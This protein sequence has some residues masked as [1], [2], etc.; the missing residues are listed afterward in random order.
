MLLITAGRRPLLP[1]RQ[2]LLHFSA[3]HPSWRPRLS[4]GLRTQNGSWSRRLLAPGRR[5]TARF[6]RQAEAS[7]R[8]LDCMGH[9]AWAL[10][11][12]CLLRAR[13]SR[14][15]DGSRFPDRSQLLDRPWQQHS[16]AA[17]A[18]W[19]R[20]ASKLVQ[21]TQGERGMSGAVTRNNGL[22]HTW[23]WLRGTTPG[24]L[25]TAIR[26][27]GWGVVPNQ[28]L[29]P[30]LANVTVGA[31][32]YT[33]YLQILGQLHEESARARRT[34]YPPPEPVHTF[35]AGLLAGALQSLVAAPLDAIQ[36]RYDHR[37]LLPADGRGGA[38]K[39]MWTFSAE[40][41]REIGPGGIFAGYGL[42]LLKDGL[43]SAVFFSTFEYV[44]AQS[45]YRF[46]TWYY[47]D[48]NEDMANLL[49]TRRPTRAGGR[50]ADNDGITPLIIK[51]HYAIEPLFLLLA[52]VTASFAQQAVMH[53]LTHFQLEHWDHLE[54]I[55]Q[56]TANRRADAAAR[57]RR[58]GAGVHLPHSSKKGEKGG[59]PRGPGDVGAVR[60]G[61]GRPRAGACAAGCTGGSG[62]TRSVRVPST[63][64]GLIIFELVRRKYGLRSDEVRINKDGYDIQL[65]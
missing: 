59:I 31:V 25:T 7:T 44:K 54:D 22:R 58:A 51:P 35:T 11:P 46:V 4:T 36:A 14:L 43:G 37:D 34:V 13:W 40:K 24:V 41:L 28:I 15:L 18:G 38:P 52:G 29:P 56:K 17:P 16:S 3:S 9:V 62:G 10:A 50:A 23:D 49:A 21:G 45:Y 60:G 39:S 48:L 26:H 1:T 63:S 65:N 6:S 42:S 55:D 8:G 27:H 5:A 32:L 33:S 47:G 57:G 19:P 12:E 64:A 2:R 61:G 53:P 30:L 20:E